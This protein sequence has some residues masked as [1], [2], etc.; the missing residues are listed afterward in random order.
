MKKKI[1]I[2]HNFYKEFGGEDANINEEVEFFSQ[3]YEVKFFSTENNERLNLYDLFSLFIQSNKKYN[4]K[5]YQIL[6]SFKPDVVYVH[7]T[8]FKLNLGIFKI[9]QS[10][11]VKTVVKIHSFRYEC[12]RYFLKKNHLKNQIRC[13]SCGF[14]R[15]NAIFFNKYYSESLIK[16]F[17]LILYSKKYFKIITS[18]F[19]NLISLN[20]FQKEKLIQCGIKGDNI[21]VIANP[22][23]FKPLNKSVNKNNILIYAGRISEEKGVDELLNAWKYSD[24]S[25][26]LLYI[27]GDGPYK[28]YL[29]EKYRNIENVEFLGA[30][31]NEKVLKIMLESKAVVTATT[32]YEGQPRLLCEAS[33][34][35]VVS[36]YPS[37]GGMD[38]FFPEEYNFSFEQYNYDD[39]I[40]KINLVSN[41]KVLSYESNRVYSNILKKLEKEKLISK[42]EKIFFEKN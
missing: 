12:S 6:K 20:Q 37:F 39:L 42:F 18:R 24:L 16:S 3:D 32:L 2:V 13:K 29:Q 5:F 30:M 28:K 26:Y 35:G 36:I 1:L 33:S 9:L 19:F 34:S 38:E 17:F 27:I 25:N 14:E 4:K 11:N 40:K 8:W 31:S 21:S 22:I 7:N 23:N 15:S 10:E 41:E